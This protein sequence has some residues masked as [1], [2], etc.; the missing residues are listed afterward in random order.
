[1]A[2]HDLDAHIARCRELYRTRLDAMDA[3]LKEHL[4]QAKWIVPDGGLFMW[5]ILPGGLDGTEFCRKAKE[6]KVMAVPG[7]AFYCNEESFSS[8]FRLNFSLPSVEQIKIGVA[9][10]GETFKEMQA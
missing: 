2:K 5:V 1:M 8:A 6:K 9:R 10:L 4:P 7:S 3:A